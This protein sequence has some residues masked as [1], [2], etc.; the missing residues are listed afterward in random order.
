[1]RA[2]Q[3]GK[4]DI[5]ALLSDSSIAWY[6]A[7]PS[8]WHAISS[9]AVAALIRNMPRETTKSDSFFLVRKSPASQL[10]NSL[11]P[12][13]CRV[14]TRRTVEAKAPSCVFLAED[15]VVLGPW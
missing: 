5:V 7:D 13:V 9:E 12:A 6:T 11:F 15:S 1:L 10:E 14:V 4:S 2:D 3:V 8:L